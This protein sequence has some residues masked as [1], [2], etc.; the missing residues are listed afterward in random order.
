[1]NVRRL[2]CCGHVMAE[3]DP[4]MLLGVSRRPGMLSRRSRL[5]GWRHDKRHR[6]RCRLSCER[7]KGTRRL[8]KSCPLWEAAKTRPKVPQLM[9]LFARRSAQRRSECCSKLRRLPA[10]LKKR[11]KPLCL[12]YGRREE[13]VQVDVLLSGKLP[14]KIDKRCG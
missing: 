14:L 4:V 9:V 10:L 12:W 2:I 11:K 3:S 8:S 13:V 1:M 7:M 5:I 6:Q